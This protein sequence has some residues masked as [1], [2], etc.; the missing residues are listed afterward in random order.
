MSEQNYACTAAYFQ[1]RAEKASGIKRRLHLLTIAQ[2]YREKACAAAETGQEV[3]VP[4]PGI[5]RRE[6]LAAMF[7]AYSPAARDAEGSTR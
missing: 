6:R 7:R 5:S 4:S 2:L 3:H 1:S